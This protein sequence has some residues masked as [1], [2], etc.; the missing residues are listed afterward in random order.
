MTLPPVSLDFLRPAGRASRSGAVLLVLGA[1]VAVATVGYQR[2][3]AQRVAV[4]EA[5]IQETRSMAER[6]LPALLT[7]EGD[8]AEV[9]EQIKQANQVLEQM[10]VP[11]G[12]LFSAVESARVAQVALLSVQ[13]DAR[14]RSVALAGEARSFGAILGYMSALEATERLRDV[15][16]L[17]HEVRS[18]QPGQPVSFTL[19]AS[20]LETR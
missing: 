10:N 20:W 8:S 15:L 9:R 4:R 19:S 14:K 17:G 7:A 16:L 6:S 11:W 12:E 1:L 3:I 5:Q 2:S 13:P 18:D